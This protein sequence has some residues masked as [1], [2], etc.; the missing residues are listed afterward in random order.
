M[1]KKK[2]IKVKAHTRVIR[3]RY[4]HKKPVLETINVRAYR[5]KK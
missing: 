4:Q 2:T 1:V 3:R 5:R